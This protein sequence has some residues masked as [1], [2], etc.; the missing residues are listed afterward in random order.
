MKT[1]KETEKLKK[2]LRDSNKER[3]PT[4]W[5]SSGSTLINMA[6]TG[7][8]SR[9]FAT[10]WYSLF[11]GD[12]NSG[13]T[14]IA[15]STLAEASINQFF[16][17]YALI[18]DNV[19]NGAQMNIERYFGR[20]LADR[21]RGPAGTRTNPVYSETTDDFYRNVRRNLNNGPCIYVLDS[22]D[23][24]STV[25]DEEVEVA[26][27]EGKKAKG[28]YGTTKAIDNSRGLRSITAKLRKTN[29]ILI[30]ISQTR[31]N[32]GFGAQF[33]PKTRAG[34]DALKFY[35]QLELWCSVKGQI[36]KKVRE[37]DRQLGIEAGIHIKKNRITGRDRK[38]AVPIYHSVGIDDVGSCID[39]L[40]DEGH[41]TESKKLIDASDF[42]FKGKREQLV[43]HIEENK[44]I[45]KLQL[46]VSKVWNEIEAE[47]QVKRKS[48]YE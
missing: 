1:D 46:L 38:V 34:G 12:S 6:M 25:E 37:K 7:K 23:A 40:V 24:L 21:I 41:W 39:Y 3:P 30:I 19:E 31:H 10:G 27:A 32:I 28:S 35:A 45:R 47:C 8:P 44:S 20:R 15:L 14:W 2:Q 33:N 43:E 36:K 29:S 5:V 13:K 4:G 9:G 18:Y 22:M 11:V 48:K 16:D 26:K 17:D 42:D